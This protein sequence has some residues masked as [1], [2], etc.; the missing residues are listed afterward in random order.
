MCARTLVTY[1]QLAEQ[2]STIDDYDARYDETFARVEEAAVEPVI[3]AGMCLEATLYDLAACL[4]GEEFVEQTEKLDPLGKFFVLAQI[5]DRQPP[6]KASVTY[7]TIQAV[8]TAR[9]KLV[10]HKSQPSPD[11]NNI[12][13]IM[14]RAKKQHNQHIQGITSSFRAL[15]LLSLYF[16]GNIFE[17]L[18]IIPSFKKQAYWANIIPKELHEDVRWCIQASVEERRQCE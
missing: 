2:L 9:N 4:F 14:G 3:Y 18:Q 16:D 17:E 5:V 11:E 15:V 1:R 8:V 10:H 6:S 12:G 7:Q 13:K